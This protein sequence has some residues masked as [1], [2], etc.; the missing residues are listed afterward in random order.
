MIHMA[1]PTP[2]FPSKASYRAA[3]TRPLA[4]GLHDEVLPRDQGEGGDE[5]DH[6][7]LW[8]DRQTAGQFDH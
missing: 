6:W 7:P 3:G 2:Y 1:E 5:E 8:A 4:P